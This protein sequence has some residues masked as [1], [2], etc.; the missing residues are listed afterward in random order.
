MIPR[1]PAKSLN[2]GVI[3]EA[4]GAQS[5]RLGG[6]CGIAIESVSDTLE[7]ETPELPGQ[8][9]CGSDCAQ[10]RYAAILDVDCNLQQI[11]AEFILQGDGKLL[12]ISSGGWFEVEAL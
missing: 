4:L 11:S 10:L 7:P 8:L 3:G 2:R 9:I 12:E 6:A 5:G 1:H